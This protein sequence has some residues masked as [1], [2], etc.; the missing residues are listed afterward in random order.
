M[1]VGLY[2]GSFDPPHVGHTI[3]AERVLEEMK[4]DEVWMVISPQNPFKAD[5]NLSHESMRLDLVRRALNGHE[6]IKPCDHEFNLPRPSY[7]V[8]TLAS[9]KKDHPDK[10]FFLIMGSD[11][12]LGIKKW[13]EADS[14]IKEIEIAV[15]PRPGYDVKEDFIKSLKGRITCVN[16]P[17]LELSS[18]EIRTRIKTG[19]A[20]RMMVKEAVWRAIERDSLYR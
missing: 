12:L 9:L 18:T 2:F 15:Y 5:Q 11:N 4:A 19:K 17:K 6:R 3:I 14:L 20:C 7:T 16:A 1:K 10:D 13:K 8:D